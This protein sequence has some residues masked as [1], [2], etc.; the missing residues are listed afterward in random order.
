MNKFAKILSTVIS[1]TLA[2]SIA[3]VML[4]SALAA[5]GAKFSMNL[6][7]E[8]DSKVVVAVKLESGWFAA[9]DFGFAA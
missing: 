9:L 2:L 4:T 3:I 7:E 8:T 6:V 1:V 5:V